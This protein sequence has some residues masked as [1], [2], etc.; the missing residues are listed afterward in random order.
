MRWSHLRRHSCPRSAPYFLASRVRVISKA[1]TLFTFRLRLSRLGENY[2][3]STR[4][5]TMARGRMCS[6]NLRG[7][8]RAIIFFLAA[9]EL[10]T[11]CKWWS[12]LPSKQPAGVRRVWSILG[13]WSTSYFRDRCST[14]CFHNLC[15]GVYFSLAEILQNIRDAL[16]GEFR[17]L[18]F[19]FLSFSPIKSV[20]NRRISLLF[21]EY[22][23][24]NVGVRE[25][26]FATRNSISCGLKSLRNAR[27]CLRN[28]FAIGKK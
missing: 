25:L 12:R 6:T 10:L 11:A 5:G 23:K 26:N 3:S 1:S 20:A 27:N 8:W 18:S 7:F 22:S 19:R 15:R 14:H 4:R 2:Y 24:L 16:R 9:R 28:V 17:R 21:K 13:V